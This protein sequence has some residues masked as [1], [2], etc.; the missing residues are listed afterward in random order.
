MVLAIVV[1]RRVVEFALAEGHRH[2]VRDVVVDDRN[3]GRDQRLVAQIRSVVQHDVGA[4]RAAEDLFDVGR[5]FFG[6]RI[7]RREGGAAVDQPAG[8]ERRVRLL[9]RVLPETHLLEQC[10]DVAVL[11]V[12]RHDHGDRAAGSVQTLSLADRGLV[13][14]KAVG[15]L[16]IVVEVSWHG[17][18]RALGVAPGARMDVAAGH[19]VDVAAGHAVDERSCLICRRA[20]GRHDRSDRRQR[21]RQDE[22]FSGDHS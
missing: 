4:G 15:L 16:E 18:V 9:A 6:G 21:G 13:R 3:V 17:D 2:N 10:G 22:V 8:E 1:G 7:G 14:G 19:A 5:R 12:A 11:H 20:E